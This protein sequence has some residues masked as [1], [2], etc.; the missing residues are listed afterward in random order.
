MLVVEFNLASRWRLLCKGLIGAVPVVL[1]FSVVL[2]VAVS[3]LPVSAQLQFKKVKQHKRDE[4]G[5]FS[6][7]EIIVAAKPDTTPAAA[8]AALDKAGVE[9]VRPLLLKPYYLVKVKTANGQPAADQATLNTAAALRATNIFK[10]SRPNYYLYAHDTVPNDPQYNVQWGYPLI[11]LPKAWDL[12]KSTPNVVLCSLDTGV[13]I[14][15]PD[16]AGRFMGAVNFTSHPN[17]ADHDAIGHGTHT[18]GTMGATTNNGVGVAGTSFGAGPL[19]AGKVLQDAGFGTSADIADGVMYLADTVKTP[20]NFV[21]INMSLG[22]DVPDDGPDL[23]QPDEA[24]IYYAATVKNC[25]VVMSA[26]NSFEDGNPASSPARVAQLDPRLFCVAACGK[27]KEHSAYSTSRAYTTIT[28]PGGNGNDFIISTL[29]TDQGSYGGNGWEGT[30]MAAPHISGVCALMLAAGAAP[31]Q[32]KQMMIQTADTVG[33]SVPN[34]DYGFGVVDAYQAVILAGSSLQLANPLDNSFV[35]NQ[36]AVK[37]TTSDPAKISSIKLTV[38]TDPTVIASGSASNLTLPWNTLATD[39]TTGAPKYPNGTHK[40]HVAVVTTSGSVQLDRTVRV[41]NPTATLTSP[42]G[43]G[44]VSKTANVIGTS[45]GLRVPTYTLEYGLGSSPSTFI[46]IVA[47]SKGKIQGGTLGTWDLT[48]IP[49]GTA[50]LRLRV[51]NPDGFEVSATSQVTVD[52]TPPT[53]PTGL[54]GVSGHQ[55]AS[56]T[57]NTSTD[58]VPGLLVGYN[59]YRSTQAASGFTLLNKNGPLTSPAYQDPNLT[60]GITYFY[61]VTAVDAAGNESAQTNFSDVTPNRNGTTSGQV[62]ALDGTYLSGATVTVQQNGTV[63]PNGLAQTDSAGQFAFAAPPGFP[64]GTYDLT[65]SAAGYV[66]QILPNG[67]TVTLGKDASNQNFALQL[68]P[69]LPVGWSMFTL[70][71]D[72]HGQNIAS[73]FPGAQVKYYNPT[74]GVYL[75]PGDPGFALPVPGVG[76]WVNYAGGSA[77]SVIKPGTPNAP[78][79]AV[80]IAVHKGWNVLGNPFQDAIHWNLN[81]LILKRADN[82]LQAS[83]NVAVSRGWSLDYAW[84]GPAG[85]TLIYDR[86]TIPGIADTIPGYGAFWFYSNIEGSLSIAPPPVTSRS[87]SGS[88]AASTGSSV[89]SYQTMK[90]AW[91]T[92]IS[93]RSGNQSSTVYIG[94]LGSGVSRRVMAA[95][96]VFDAG[97]NLTLSLTGDGTGLGTADAATPGFA[98]DLRSTMAGTQTWDVT[99]GST[100]SSSGDQPVVLTWP[101]ASRVPRGWTLNLVDKSTGQRYNLR[102]TSS[103]TLS[104]LGSST[105]ATRAVHSLQLELSRESG[106]R[107]LI[108]DLAVNVGNGRAGTASAMPNISFNLS[109]EG[110]VS[111]SIIRAN[112]DTVRTLSANRS[113]KV[114]QNSLVWDTKDSQGRSV[115][116]GVY[117]V[118][119]RA[120]G[121]KGDSARAVV[122]FVITR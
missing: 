79:Q 49:D 69:V 102:N 57:W 39:P 9:V 24:A 103:V 81:N 73:V 10:W 13:D 109:K 53:I 84:G 90:N 18:T 27:Q 63:V 2:L 107:M 82:G 119:V 56:L 7:G 105:G 77:P 43:G 78:I 112:G 3:A 12:V 37:L 93:A 44:Y 45:D 64:A 100:G 6:P 83:L 8:Q 16:L 113:I 48:G 101:G 106:Q 96:P 25:V 86:G 36:V 33:R 80:S 62:I 98:V 120:N 19:F 111:L 92:E 68:Q 115:S 52:Q 72:F 51:K 54:T 42:S 122:S 23:Q 97:Q 71:Y 4:P 70:P 114:G 87:V 108:T 91:T 67:F 66:P 121:D 38:D 59:I 95:P 31:D 40:L 32:L 1:I 61:K 50:Q 74:T 26:G 89:P 28:A 58:P 30:S 41:D 94:V 117:L 29:P 11:N 46:P 110:Q 47:N 99:L 88:R 85:K 5:S 60:N 20:T 17:N 118:Q 76:Y 116:P 75:N 14:N 34:S 104:P 21:V 35:S 55:T 22:A 15:H 65:A